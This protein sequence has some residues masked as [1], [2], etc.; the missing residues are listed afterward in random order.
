MVSVVPSQVASAVDYALRHPLTDEN[1]SKSVV[2]VDVGAATTSIALATFEPE[3]V[4]VRFLLLDE[5]CYI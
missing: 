1:S 5:N 4:N 3:I 2:L